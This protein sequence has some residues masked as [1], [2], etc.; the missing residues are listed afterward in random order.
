MA[1]IAANL[2][3]PALRDDGPCANPSIPLVFG[4]NGVS[5]FGFERSPPPAR[6]SASESGAGFGF[7]RFGPGA[8]RMTGIGVLSRGSGSS[9]AKRSPFWPR[10][11]RAGKKSSINISEI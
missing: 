10:P 11:R 9:I 8:S 5:D 7:A 1:G 2:R 6:R 3:I 4:M